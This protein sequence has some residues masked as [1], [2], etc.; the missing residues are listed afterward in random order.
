MTKNS[1]II[2]T[3]FRLILTEDRYFHKESGERPD[4]MYLS[5]ELVGGFPSLDDLLYVS[6]DGSSVVFGAMNEVNRC[7]YRLSGRSPAMDFLHSSLVTYCSAVRVMAGKVDQEV[8]VIP[9]LNATVTAQEVTND[10]QLILNVS[11]HFVLLF[12]VRYFPVRPKFSFAQPS[13]GKRNVTVWH[14]SVCPAICLSR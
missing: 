13:S 11:Q 7:N 1:L 14:P 6:V 12:K 8:S 4:T 10:S 3:L 9:F 2:A 5:V